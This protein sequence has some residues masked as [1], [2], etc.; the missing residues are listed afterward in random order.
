MIKKLGEKEFYTLE[1]LKE[2][3]WTK[4]DTFTSWV[5]YRPVRRIK[6]IFYEIK[7]GFQRMFRGYDDTEIF[8]LD[9]AFID[10]Y[11]K[12]LQDF[13]ESTCGYP[14]T[15]TEEEWDAILDRMIFLLLEI[16]NVYDDINFE[17]YKEKDKIIEADKNEFFELFSKHFF[18]L[19][20]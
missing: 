19:W 11:T 20:Y 16:Q 12:I 7:Y 5:W 17:D 8:N 10:K 1:D 15:M 13:R 14:G 6:H 2:L 18:H 4:W 3:K 9:W